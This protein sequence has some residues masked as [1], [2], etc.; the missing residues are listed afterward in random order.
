M[1]NN[2]I[3]FYTNG[4]NLRVVYRSPVCWEYYLMADFNPY[5]NTLKFYHGKE[6]DERAKFTDNMHP[7]LFREIPED[8]A[9]SWL[10]DDMI[11]ALESLDRSSPDYYDATTLLNHIRSEHII[12]EEDKSL[13]ES[14]IVR[15]LEMNRKNHFADIAVEKCYAGVTGD[16]DIRMEAHNNDDKNIPASMAIGVSCISMQHAATIEAELH[17]LGY[18]GKAN[19][20]NGATE[21]TCIVYI[22]KI[23][24]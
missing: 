3:S 18:K 14:A 23:K 7:E 13:S 4:K 1:R 17:K 20:A 22:Y 9:D 12:L 24:E 6:M 5:D 15:L 19:Y 21:K 16:L 10:R 8:G 2:A 11:K